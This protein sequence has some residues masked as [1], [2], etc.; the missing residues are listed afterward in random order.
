MMTKALSRSLSLS[1]A[2]SL[3]NVVVVVVFSYY[4]DG[5]NNYLLRFVSDSIVGATTIV[6]YVVDITHASPANP[7]HPATKQ[8]TVSSHRV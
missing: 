3:S 6:W 1:L 5:I 7:A 2:L 4:D 8:P